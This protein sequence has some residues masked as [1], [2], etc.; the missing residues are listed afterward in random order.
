[1]QPVSQLDENHSDVVDHGEEHL[2]QV[3]SL[4]RFLP[5]ASALPIVG[6][7]GDAT[8]LLT[9]STSFATRPP[10]L[11]ST[12]S[13]VIGVSSITSWSRAAAIVS[14]SS[15]MRAR[16]VATAIGCMA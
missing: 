12:R 14:A 13:S 2:A 8:S 4:L 10:N 16:I 15:C 3:L 7:P 5:R 6:C 1:M 11:A 9:P